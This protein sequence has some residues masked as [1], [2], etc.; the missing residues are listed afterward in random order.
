M[1]IKDCRDGIGITGDRLSRTQ[2][3][4]H[5]WEHTYSPV[6]LWYVIRC[7]DRKIPRS[8]WV[9]YHCCTAESN[10]WSCSMEENMDPRLSSDFPAYHIL[11]CVHLHGPKAILWL[12]CTPH[13]AMC[14]PALTNT[15]VNVRITLFLPHNIIN[16]GGI[17][18]LI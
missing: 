11:P 15:Y 14:A 17:Y 5:M 16:G 3:K 9:K 7:K 6:C 10:K 1:K 18:F 4:T 13:T 2:D 8:S 12:H